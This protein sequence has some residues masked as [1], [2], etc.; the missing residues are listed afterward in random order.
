MDGR[1]GHDLTVTVALAAPAPNTPRGGPSPPR[2]GGD[3]ASRQPFAGPRPA[4]DAG[5]YLTRV[6]GIGELEAVAEGLSRMRFF[7]L[8]LGGIPRLV[9]QD[10]GLVLAPDGRNLAAVVHRL[11]ADAPDTLDR[12][13]EY[14]R[15]VQP[16]L[17]RIE[18]VAIDDFVTVDFLLR[19]G[20]RVQRFPIPSMSDGTLNALAVLVAAFQPTAKLKEPPVL[21]GLEEPEKA[22]HPAVST[23]LADAFLEASHSVQVVVTSHSPDLLEHEELEAGSLIAVVA[24]DGITRLGPLDGF[25]RSVLRDRLSTAGELHRQNQLRPEGA[26]VSG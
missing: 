14:L 3:P 10:P 18:A 2:Q 26:A 6:S 16:N 25:G 9:E 15:V 12:V 7:N 22:L 24:E 11:Q 21:V 5:L 13:T 4:A 1:P 19:V 20:T 17:E 8:H 23:L